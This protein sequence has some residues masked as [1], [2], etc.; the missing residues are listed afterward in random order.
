MTEINWI[1]NYLNETEE[2][3][4]ATSDYIWENPE[5]RFEEFASARYLAER[6]EKEGF[7]VYGNIANIETAFYAEYSQNEGGPVIAFLG[8]YDALPNL[9]QESGTPQQKPL[10]E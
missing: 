4:T 10:I 1:E 9:S 8:E 5:I 3:W 6:L 7:T 2:K